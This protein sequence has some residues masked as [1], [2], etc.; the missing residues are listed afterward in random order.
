[1][2][3]LHTATAAETALNVARIRQDFPALRQQ[4]H[5]Q[6]LVFL[7]S[8]A[9]SQ[10]P[11]QVLDAMEQVYRT[12]YANVHRGAYAYSRR[13]T[14][15]YEQAR[16]TIARFIG[17]PSDSQIVFTRNATEALN[18]V[19]FSYARAFLGPGDEIVLTELEHHANYLPWLALAQER[20]VILKLIPLAADGT[21]DLSGLDELITPRA[22]LVSFA[23]ISNVLGTIT[24]PRPIV[25]RAHAVGAVA[26]IDACQSAPHMPLDV[27]ALDTDFLVFSG[28]KMLG[29]TGIGVL[30]GRAEL[31]AAMP[32]FMTGGDVARDVGFDE[33]VWED[34]PLKFE[35]GTPAFVEAIGLAAAVEYLEAVGL[36]AVREHER[37]LTAHALRRLAEL[38]GLRVYGPAD[39]DLRGGVVTFTIEGIAPG[40]LAAELDQ[41]GIAVRSGRHCAHPLHRRLGLSATTRASFAI[42]NDLSDVDALVEGIAD[43]QHVPIARGRAALAGCRDQPVRR[44]DCSAVA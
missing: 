3:S 16:A 25:A 12:T 22:R 44:A 21:L 42:Y 29:P 35:A 14:D 28:H 38:P 40:D 43:I 20:G 9:S 17:A 31:L 39:A 30:Y 10:K 19:A 7:D 41:R 32:P 36:P 5:D 4:V 13:S 2:G 34:A 8:A 37:C 23:H 11:V 33:V 26:V 6:R 27:R 1:M 24:D 15:L 18:L